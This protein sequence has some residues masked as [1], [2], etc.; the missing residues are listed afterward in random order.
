MSDATLWKPFPRNGIRLFRSGYL[1]ADEIKERRLQRE[2]PVLE[3]LGSWLEKQNP[4]KGTRFD[5]AVTY[6]CNRRDLLENYLLDGRCSFSN[7]ASERAVKQG[8][9]ARKTGCSR[10]FHPKRRQVL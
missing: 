1:A 5:K 10:S 4:E 7:N 9:L 6:T 3:G 2:K 8:V